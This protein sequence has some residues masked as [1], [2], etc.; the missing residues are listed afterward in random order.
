MIE[1]SSKQISVVDVWRVPLITISVLLVALLLIYLPTTMSM[2]NTWNS[3][4]TF[5]HGYLILPI[6]LW[7][8]WRNRHHFQPVQPVVNYYAIPLILI[9]SFAWL[10]AYFVDVQVI[11]QLAMV[12][13]IP[14][15]VF[16]LLGWQVTKTAIFPLFFLVFAVPMGEA[17]VPYLIE[18]TADFTVAMVQLTGIPIYR[19]GTFFQLPTGN[20]SVVEACSGVRYLIAS[21]TLGFLYAYLT[22][23]SFYRRALFVIASI[24]VPIIANGLRAFM[25]VMIGHFSDMQLAT[26]VDHLIYGWI[27]FGFVIAIMFYVGSFWHEQG[28]DAKTLNVDSNQNYTAVSNVNQ[29]QFII[30]LIVLFVS[31]LFMPLMAYTSNNNVNNVNNVTVALKAPVNNEWIKT[32]QLVTNWTP[33][34]KNMDASVVQNYHKKKNNVDL[35]IG[36]Y[37][38]QR[39]DAQL[40]TSSNVI[41][42]EIEEWKNIGES[43]ITLT[44]LSKNTPVSLA[45][46]KSGNQEILVAY[47]KYLGGEV[48]TNNY[49]AK[50]IEAKTRLFGGDRSASIIAISVELK[51]DREQAISSIQSFAQ[52]INQSLFQA[53][54]VA[55]QSQ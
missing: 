33:R 43:S 42:E 35:F 41:T 6:S 18:F 21:V 31:L 54:T 34:Y 36:Y 19:E 30:A 51:E 32:E 3:S 46:L 2:I 17:L 39:D 26:G 22:Y 24:L 45:H 28:G 14:L 52:D 44:L 55:G 47:F 5:T 40:I 37:I 1:K 15:I 4:E 12:S 13:L 29:N 10:V 8:I 49:V 20:W 23:Q 38:T 11:Q 7:L 9:A 48:V 50:F 16:G 53:I 27:F 25:I